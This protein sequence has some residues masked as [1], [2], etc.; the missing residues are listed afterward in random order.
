MSEFAVVLVLGAAVLHATW[1]AI[2]KG[3]RARA[4]VLAA[5]AGTHGTVGLIL[6]L[7]AETPL[8]ASW[9]YIAASATTH[10]GY[11]YFLS[12]AYKWGDLS[13]VYPISRGIAPLLVSLGAL[14]FA[15][16][17]LSSQGW[18]G[19][20]LVSA[21]I[22]LLAFFSKGPSVPDPRS[23]LAAIATGLIIAT[24]SVV[25]GIGV[26]L[27]GSPFGYMGWLFF[28][29]FLVSL[30][31]FTRL[32]PSFTPEVRATLRVGYLG[33]L[34]AVVAYGLVIYANTLAPLG[35]VS[36]LRESSV[37][38][39]ALFGVVIFRERPWISRLAAAVIVG[40]GVLMLTLAR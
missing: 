33:G 9:P 8:P 31:V 20:A 19:I 34:C 2:V 10:Y 35:M 24:Y 30:F 37:I 12:M 13:R 15:G 11:Y 21:G 27:S 23:T 25:D 36:A 28:S 6:L 14:V 18:A 22:C 7:W 17:M 39:A 1:N 26:R 29:E 3:T 16:E 32:R 5:V 40:A 4:L 38:I